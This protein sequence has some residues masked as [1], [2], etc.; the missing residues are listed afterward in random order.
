MAA[1]ITRSAAR[2]LGSAAAVAAGMAIARE[3]IARSR[4]YD[5]HGRSV[6][7]TGGS[8][9]LGL[10]LARFLAEMDCRI[11]IC[12]RDEDELTRAKADIESRG[13][14]VFPELCDLTNPESAG[15]M[16][17]DVLAR[18]AHIDV[19]INNAGEITV[20]PWL[21]MTDS[22]YHRAMNIHFWAAVHVTRAVLPQMLR[23]HEGRIVNISS[24]GGKVPV[25]HLA[26]YC[27]SKFALA[28]WSG[29]LRAE[30]L[31]ENI[32]VTTVYP[33]LM[34]TGSHVQG[35]FKGEQEKEYAWFKWSLAVPGSALSAERAADRILRAAS[36][37]E[38]EVLVGPQAFLAA[39][40]HN[41]VPEWS[42]DALAVMNRFLPRS[43]AVGDPTRRLKG[44]ESESPRT[45]W[46]WVRTLDKQAIDKNELG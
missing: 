4:F 38:A 31:R 2:A 23:R 43:P 26:P 21:D 15:R 1:W 33:W 34:R 25:P 11:A 20:G 30:L 41:I 13:G 46:G 6:L 17:R 22:D 9:G 14:E 18:F 32:Y 5:L 44:F 40:V 37:G 29:A 39:K 8:R 16:V 27:A 10:T 12:A 36:R 7:I 19:L 24:I 3:L 45:N 35:G 28:G 42:S